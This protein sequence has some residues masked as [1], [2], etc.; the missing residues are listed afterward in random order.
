MNIILLGN[1]FDLAHGLPTT[2]TNFLDFLK[3]IGAKNNRI[4]YDVQLNEQLSDIMRNNDNRD[5]LIKIRKLCTNNVWSKYFLNRNHLYPNWCDFESEIEYITRNLQNIKKELEKTRELPSSEFFRSP[6]SGFFMLSIQQY[7]F[8]IIYENKDVK[9]GFIDIPFDHIPPNITITLGNNSLD[10]NNVNKVIFSNNIPPTAIHIP[11]EYLISFIIDQLNDFTKCFELYLS[12]FVNHIS[13]QKINFI[14]K[15][16]DSSN[17]KI[18]NFNYTNTINNYRFPYNFD[19]CYIHGE[20]SD[21]NDNH[22][23]LGINETGNDIDPM[24]TRFRKYFQRFEK[25]CTFNYR[26]WINSINYHNVGRKLYLG[27][28]EHNLYIIGHSLTLNDKNILNEL[29]TLP[30]MSTTIYYHSEISKLSLMQNLAA[31]LGPQKFTEYMEAN[32]VK[33]EQG[34]FEKKII[35][36]FG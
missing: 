28:A 16:T 30:G 19:I 22:L 10:K 27:S 9:E 1:G 8:N 3:R 26:T 23:V 5:T 25:N 33:F 32:A 17:L 35:Q 2:Y 18:L 29:I 31:I 4:I 13:I 14:D 24:F 15:L 21:G 11:F 34:E 6:S 36:V 12:K 20:A 7:L